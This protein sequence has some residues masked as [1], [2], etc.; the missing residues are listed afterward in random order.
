MIC[1]RIRRNF[2]YRC[3]FQL[4]C[5]PPQT[6]DVI[7]FAQFEGEDILP[8]TRNDAESCVESDNESIMMSKQDMDNINSGDESDH[9]L[10]STDIL[11]DICDGSIPIR[12]LTEEKHVTKY[13]ILLD[14]DNQNGKEHLKI[15]EAWE[16]VYTRYLV[17]L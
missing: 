3:E 10:I 16:K 14:K 4:I 8:E 7:T 9:D 17:M 2:L 13:V 15:R 5:S 1:Y 12:T 11:E 6:G